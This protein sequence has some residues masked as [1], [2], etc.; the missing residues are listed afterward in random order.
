MSDK[1][2]QYRCHFLL[3]LLDQHDDINVIDQHD[4]LWTI[5]EA[6]ISLDCIILEGKRVNTALAKNCKGIL[7]SILLL[8]Q[9][10]TSFQLPDRLLGSHT[11]PWAIFDQP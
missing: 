9:V 11:Q 1:G 5:H 2:L 4:I 3:V 7:L 6:L 8:Q 10:K